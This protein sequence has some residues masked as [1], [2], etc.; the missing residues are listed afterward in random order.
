MKSTK[1]F[2]IMAITALTAIAPLAIAPTA[3]A[4]PRYQTAPQNSPQ[5]ERRED[6]RDD[7]RDERRDDRRDDR[8]YDRRD[9]R[10]QARWDARQ[11][12]GYSYNGQWRYGPAP[13]AYYGRR[14]FEPGYR[15]W[16]RGERVPAYYRDRAHRVDYRQHRNLR[17]PPRGYTYVRDDRGTILLVGIATGVVLSAILSN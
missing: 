3:S 17:A 8:R 7:R 2:A 1:R 4:D 5:A 12:N 10:Q 13:T 9:A 14:G 6:R 15:A 11:H 16:N